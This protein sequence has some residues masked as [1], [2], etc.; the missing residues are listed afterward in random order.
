MEIGFDLV[1][2]NPFGGISLQINYTKWVHEVSKV[3][4][5]CQSV[6]LSPWSLRGAAGRLGVGHGYTQSCG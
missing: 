6:V 5:T 4:S 3:Y 1:A 2:Q